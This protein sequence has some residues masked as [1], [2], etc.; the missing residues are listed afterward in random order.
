MPLVSAKHF[1]DV[2]PRLH[3]GNNVCVY[4]ERSEAE[5]RAR[6]QRRAVGPELRSECKA[7]VLGRQ[8]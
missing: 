1:L 3:P 4:S 6:E 5:G 2:N 7:R 8:K